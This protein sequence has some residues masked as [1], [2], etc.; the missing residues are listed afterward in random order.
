MSIKK[1]I[2]VALMV[3]LAMPSTSFATSTP[4]FPSCIIPTGQV[5]ASYQDGTHGVPGDA[6]TY[7]GE[8]TVYKLDSE[9]VVQCL[10][11]ANSEGIQTNW[12][13]VSSL[14]SDQI[15]LLKRDGWNYIPNGVL[16]GLE[17]TPY[18]TKNS[19]Y[20]CRGRGGL[21]AGTS[22]GEVLGISTLAQAGNLYEIIS[23]FSLA[24]GCLL[25]SALFYFLGKKIHKS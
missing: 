16:W 9:L 18:L 4:S 5:I 7:T 3:Y 23:Y 24:I 1:V 11:T 6:N 12:W 19:E 15:E 20:E 21:V 25:C 8:D 13:K 10:C 14:S 17:S 2:S 22:T